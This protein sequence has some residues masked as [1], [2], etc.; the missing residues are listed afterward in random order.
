M[1]AAYI[2]VL[3]NEPI[4]SLGQHLPAPPS[5]ILPFTVGTNGAL[6]A[7]TGGV[8]PDDPTLANPI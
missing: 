8:V 5:Q 6:Q 2:Y 3:D 1:P 7:E 4:T